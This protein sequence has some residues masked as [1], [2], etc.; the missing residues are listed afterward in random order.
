MRNGY[1]HRSMLMTMADNRLSQDA[2][3]RIQ[4][5]V[6]QMHQARKHYRYCDLTGAFLSISEDGL[7][8]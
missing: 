6:A 4:Q 2:T 8:Q 3:L 1:R 5:A 7:N